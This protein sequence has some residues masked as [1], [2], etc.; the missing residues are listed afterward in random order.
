MGHDSMDR[1]CLGCHQQ[2]AH[3]D[4]WEDCYLCLNCGAILYPSDYG[5]EKNPNAGIWQLVKDT[6]VQ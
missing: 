4:T 1:E 2:T 6:A 3:Y 5:E